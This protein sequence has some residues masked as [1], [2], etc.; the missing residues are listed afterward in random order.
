VITSAEIFCIS[1]RKKEH[2]N[3]NN[4]NQYIQHKREGEGGGNFIIN[5]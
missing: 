3:I 2:N 5:I 1:K 4:I